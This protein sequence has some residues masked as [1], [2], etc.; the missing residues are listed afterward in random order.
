MDGRRRLTC[1]VGVTDGKTVTI[2]GDSAATGEDS[3]FICT[4]ADTKVWAADGWAFGFTSSYR[5]GQLLRYAF[6][7]PPRAVDQTLEHYMVTTFIDGVRQC[8][9]DGGWVEIEN[10]VE[11]GGQFLVGHQGR[12]FSVCSDFQVA[13]SVHSFDACGCGDLVALGALH[14]LPKTLPPREKVRRALEVAQECSAA[15]RGP[16]EIVAV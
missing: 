4:R 2:G 1:I 7:P 5:M 15:V 8:L 11:S 13:E 14:A 10:S 9:K 16:F 6:T 12:L 3:L